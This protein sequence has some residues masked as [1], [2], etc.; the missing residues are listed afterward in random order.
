MS[1][2]V[3][4]PSTTDSPGM[5]GSVGA[6]EQRVA[7][8][9]DNWKR[10]LL[11]LSKR[12]RSLNFRMNK[13]ST[14][15]IVDEQPAEVFRQLCLKGQS[16]RFKPAPE[17]VSQTVPASENN[18]GKASSESNP[19]GCATEP[20]TEPTAEV[21]LPIDEEDD[22]SLSLDFIPYDTE[23]LDTRHTDDLLQTTSTPEQLDKSLRR[24]DE[25]A[26]T[27]IDEQGV[28]ALF[29]ALGMLH[30]KESTDSNELFKAPLVLVPVELT[31]KS[32]R[33]GYVVKA[34]DDDPIVNPALIEYLCRGFGIIL[35]D[36][37]DLSTISDDYDL[38]TFLKAVS[39]SIAAQKGWA[40]KTDISLGLFSF[41]KFVMYKDLEAN[42]QALSAHRLVR[43]LITRSGTQMGGL[44]D[45]V[46]SME[47]DRDYPPEATFQVVD[48]DSS[49]LRA[50]AAVSRNHD[51]VLQG[52]PGTGKSQTITNLIAQ[53]LVAGKSVLF[54]AE[55][56]A[57]LQVVHSRLVSAGLGEFCLEL[58]ST[59]ANKR[60]VMQELAASLDASLQRFGA[61]TL[62]TQRLPQVRASLTEYAKAVHAPY[63]TLGISPYHAY[64]ELGAVLNAPKLK[65][66]G[67]V[68]TITCMQ[69]DATGRALNDLAVA[70]GAVGDPRVHPWRDTSRTFYSE[71]DL[72]TIRELADDLGRRLADIMRQGQAIEAVFNLPPIRTFADVETAAAV[73]AV[74]A[75]SPGAPLAVLES[76][77]WNAPPPEA[78]A[79]V[80]RGRTIVR[81]KE[82][83]GQRFTVEALEQ[84]YASDIAYVEQKS[85]GFLSFLAFFDGHYH[86][87]KRRWKAYRL[88]PYRGTLLE[89]A[90][91]MK[92]IDQLQREQQALAAQDALA[93]QLFGGLW[94]SEQSSWDVLEN[95]VRWVVEFRGMCVRHGLSRRA[96]EVASRAAPDVSAVHALRDAV[97]A[98][99]P[100][101]VS[102]RTALGWP[103]NYLADAPIET[104]TERIASLGTNLAL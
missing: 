83:V 51:L 104:I 97:A 94:Q 95:Y 8:S 66:S 27:I 61:P 9:V 73:A 65:Y 85:Q 20:A 21:A 93:R 36:L 90:E 23:T 48:A 81:L 26:R 38:Q 43:Q 24:I 102:L 101:L 87:I 77:A 13:V 59:K 46:R 40:V 18:D 39:D 12:N 63:G 76:D 11:D 6:V 74:L 79:L 78:I 42:T 2:P 86:A 92:K 64:G 75:R 69:L 62:S 98:A 45:E 31:R 103:E 28:N 72:D 68:D 5:S 22:G 16:M 67:A 49:Q 47:L 80:E 82:H 91:E 57:A 70:A 35:P 19:A 99:L 50:I 4:S 17:R 3:Q 53:A 30:Y 41:Q 71:D 60:A 1:A 55:K 33:S 84:D 100:V 54:V 37:P 7:A 96:I 52:P 10:K 44:P 88:P 58:H 56:M 89:Q 29:L 32:A 25:Q 14:I 15:A 34:A